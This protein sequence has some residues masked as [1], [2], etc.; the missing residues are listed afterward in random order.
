MTSILTQALAEQHVAE[1]INQAERSTLRRSLRKARREARA[2]RRLMAGAGI[3][4]TNVSVGLT[5][6]IRVATAR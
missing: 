2:Q 5:D 6:R 3:G 1:L 4:P